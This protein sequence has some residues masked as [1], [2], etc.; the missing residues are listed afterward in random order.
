MNK[1]V[2]IQT[3]GCQ[4]N[5]HDSMAMMNRLQEIGFEETN[6]PEEASLII[7]N[8]CSVRE[9]A[10]QKAKSA[11]GALRKFKDKKNPP[12]VVVAGCV[13][14]QEGG[15]WFDLYPHV[16]V[17]MGTDAVTRVDE[18][19]EKVRK[20]SG[21]IID[22]D[23]DYDD[24]SDFP[25]FIPEN[26]AATATVVITKGCNCNCT[27]CIVPL[28]RGPERCRPP[29]EI[30]E[31]V[32]SLAKR[33]V[34]EVILLG[35]SVNSWKYEGMSFA[36]LLEEI[37]AIDGIKRIRYTSPSPAEVTEELAGVHGRI[38]SLCEHIHLPVQSGSNK[39]L[40]K[41]G[42]KYTREKYIEVI[43]MLKDACP[44]MVFSTDII[45]GFPG[46]TESDFEQTLNL[47][48]EVRFDTMFSFKYSPR[49]GTPAYSF[50][51][52]VSPEVKQERLEKLHRLSE[53]IT[54]AN[55]NEDSGKEVEVLVEKEGKI[56]GQLSGR[57]KKNRIVNFS[58]DES[59][60]LAP[61]DIAMVKIEEILPHSLRGKAVK[62]I[63]S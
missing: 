36:K 31:N 32:K 12:I 52:D 61:G 15:K 20:G 37:S 62:I 49:P 4:M 43:S 21:K 46:E 63:N 33:G 58:C 9:K 2:Y 48:R 7:V 54:M 40:K 59:L 26:N 60:K 50:E 28:L 6:R 18:I 11:I 45:V 57:T 25:S 30:I 38:P 14:K 13:A 27:F 53:E 16:D 35:Q 19:V 1:K 24:F 56:K 8:T 55:W 23:F 51:D 22:I 44:S 29:H 34:K 3:F 10:Y 39:I 41:M 17:V 5:D 47:V 42:R